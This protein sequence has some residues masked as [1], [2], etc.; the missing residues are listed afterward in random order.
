MSFKLIQLQL[1]VDL[2]SVRTWFNI[3]T[4]ASRSKFSLRSVNFC[5][6]LLVRS[7]A[8]PSGKL[9]SVCTG[10]PNLL[11]QEEEESTVHTRGCGG[12]K[13]YD[14]VRC[15]FDQVNKRR[16]GSF[17]YGLFRMLYHRLKEGPHFFQAIDQPSH[18]LESL[19]FLEFLQAVFG[20]ILITATDQC[21][22]SNTYLPCLGA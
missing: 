20:V 19:H 4:P 1:L 18:L 3:C 5:S 16:Y 9:R 22:P 7:E 15:I 21:A 8:N 14:E 17:Q 6:S 11:D 10:L 13:I 2:Q 12:C